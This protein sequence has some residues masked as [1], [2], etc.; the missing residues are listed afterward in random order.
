MALTIHKYVFLFSLGV[1]HSS[2]GD[3]DLVILA[4]IKTWGHQFG[5]GMGMD[6]N[7]VCILEVVACREWKVIDLSS[8]SAC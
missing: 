3:Q 5:V 4:P 8:V 2:Q 6:I 7:S 1:S